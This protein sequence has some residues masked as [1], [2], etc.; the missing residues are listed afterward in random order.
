MD[1]I[2]QGLSEL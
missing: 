2:T 1:D